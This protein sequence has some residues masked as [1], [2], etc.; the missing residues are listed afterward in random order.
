M[1]G[2]AAYVGERLRDLD[3]QMTRTSLL[4]VTSVLQELSVGLQVC[5]ASYLRRS[6]IQPQGMILKPCRSASPARSL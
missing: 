3:G 2:D 4:K 6:N 1:V 5:R